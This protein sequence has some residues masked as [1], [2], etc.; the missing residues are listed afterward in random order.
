MCFWT[1]SGSRACQ[2]DEKKSTFQELNWYEIYHHFCRAVEAFKCLE[3]WFLS[4]LLKSWKWKVTS[5]GPPQRLST[6]LAQNLQEV[7]VRDEVEAREELT[8]MSACSFC[9]SQFVSSSYGAKPNFWGSNASSPSSH[10]AS[11]EYFP[12][13][14]KIPKSFPKILANHETIYYILLP[15]QLDSFCTQQGN[16]EWVKPKKWASNKNGHL[17]HSRVLRRPQKTANSSAGWGA[18]WNSF[19]T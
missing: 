14:S 10:W 17:L 8:L 18:S 2:K 19:W 1:C 5:F 12:E 3:L 7:V 4:T 6:G 13:S 16:L 15:I 11:F 9:P